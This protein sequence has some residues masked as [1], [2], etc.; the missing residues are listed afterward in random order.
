MLRASLRRPFAAAV[1]GVTLL[2]AFAPAA[3]ARTTGTFVVTACEDATNINISATWSGI[4]ADTISF[5]AGSHGGGLGVLVDLGGVVSSGSMS[6]SFPIDPTDNYT[7]AGASL[8][9]GGFARANTVASVTLHKKGG[10]PA[11]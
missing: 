2:A 9:L 3:L 7:T 6:Q 1:L 8:L 4:S 5:G 10:W 11:C